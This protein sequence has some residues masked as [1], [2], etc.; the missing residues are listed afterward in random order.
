M[1]VKPRDVPGLRDRLI[2]NINRA[3]GNLPDAV[4][5][6][7]VRVNDQPV[8]DAVSN[9]EWTVRALY[10]GKVQLIWVSTETLRVAARV[11]ETIPVDTLF[12]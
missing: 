8:L 2:G 12:H 9:L 3:L 7:E 5:T 1:S 10:S 11:A 4:A 6:G